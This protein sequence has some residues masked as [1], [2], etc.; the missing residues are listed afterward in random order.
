MAIEFGRHY[1][2]R[3][4]GDNSIL[5]EILDVYTRNYIIIFSLYVGFTTIQIRRF[6]RCWKNAQ[7]SQ[8]SDTGS[9]L[10][11]LKHPGENPQ[12]W[13]EKKFGFLPHPKT[14][15]AT[16]LNDKV[17]PKFFE[18]EWKWCRSATDFVKQYHTEGRRQYD[19]Y[20]N[21]ELLRYNIQQI[22]NQ[23]IQGSAGSLFA[24]E[25]VLNPND[26][27]SITFNKRRLE[28]MEE[29][30]EK[31]RSSLQKEDG[32]LFTKNGK[33]ISG[34]LCAHTFNEDCFVTLSSLKHD[35]KDAMVKLEA[36]DQKYK[37]MYPLRGSFVSKKRKQK[38]NRAK[39]RKRRLVRKDVNCKRVFSL[40]TSSA[41]YSAKANASIINLSQ[42]SK[43]TKRDGKWLTVLIQEEK[44][45]E[46]AVFQMKPFLQTST[47]DDDTC[48]FTDSDYDAD[49]EHFEL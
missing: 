13:K 9:V 33:I 10:T 7:S 22:L 11:F 46:D 23:N 19:L 24:E 5:D 36:I 26:N 2:I 40:I 41:D 25:K 21:L 38:E 6:Q 35:I 45:T 18:S 1:C 47:E 3:S 20:K 14:E 12:P 16:F 32:Q 49:N 48:T 31:I 17:L 37:R 8:H 15:R 34:E 30:V 43:L 44:F 27:Q 42:I 4:I 29:K 39:S 28:E